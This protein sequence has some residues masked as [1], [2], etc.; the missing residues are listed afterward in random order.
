[1]FLGLKTIAIQY[2]DIQSAFDVFKSTVSANIIRTCFK[3]KTIRISG[4]K[5]WSILNISFAKTWIW[6]SKVR[7]ESI[8]IPSNTCSSSDEH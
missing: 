8:V 3:Y 1:M 4:D 5:P 2:R 7:L 6:V